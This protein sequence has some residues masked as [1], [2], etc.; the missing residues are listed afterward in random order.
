MSTT[1]TH[2]PNNL[3]ELAAHI[4]Q[5]HASLQIGEPLPWSGTVL[6]TDAARDEHTQAVLIATERGWI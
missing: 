1:P 5:Q 2:L 3:A 4:A 6:P